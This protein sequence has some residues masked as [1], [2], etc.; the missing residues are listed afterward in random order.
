MKFRGIIAFV[1]ALACSP[2]L[3]QTNPG[4]S[5]LSIAKGG[6]NCSTPS[7]VCLGNIIGPAVGGIDQNLLSSHTANYTLSTTDCGSTVT[8]GGNAFFTL[9]VPAVAG[10]PASCS[11]AVVNI[12]T[13]GSGRAKLISGVTLPGGTGSGIQN[14]LWPTQNFSIKIENGSWTV[15]YAPLRIK[16]QGAA[17]FNTDFVNGNDANDGLATGAGN[18]FKTVSQCMQNIY[19]IFDDDA[20][21][22]GVTCL[23]AAGTTDSTTIHVASHGGFPGSFGTSGVT[24]DGNGTAT[25]SGGIQIYYG[26]VIAVQAVTLTN[27]GGDCVQVQFGGHIS[28]NAGVTFGACSGTAIDIL[29]GGYG[30]FN[31]N[32]TWSGNTP[33]F[34][35]L[36]NG[37]IFNGNGVTVTLGAN[38]TVTETVAANW[39]SLANLNAMTWTLGA[40]TVTG[41]KFLCAGNS[42]IVGATGI[43]GTVAGSVSGG[44]NLDGNPT[45]V[46][47]GGTGLAAGT[48]G[49]I[50][51]FQ[52]STQMATSAL[53]A[54]NQLM[55]GG[56]TGAPPSTLGSLGTTTQVLHGNAG[57]LPTWAQVGLTADVTG[58]LPGGNGGTNNAFMQFSGPATSTKTYTLP[59]ASA[60][61]LTTNGAVFSSTVTNPTGTTSV[62]TQKM[63]GMGATCTITPTTSTRVHFQ[64]VGQVLNN[65]VND[66][67][68]GQLAYGTGTAPVNGAAAT[69]TNIGNG[70]VLS[71][72]TAGTGYPFNMSGVAT[73]LTPGTAVWFDLSLSALVGGTASVSNV[74]CVAFEM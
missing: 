24:I 57:G 62:G 63:M 69:G 38:A 43:P 61:I 46:S 65:T 60:S 58:T 35:L 47:A 33:I 32:V 55:A 27:A 1:F 28:F 5:P 2:A 10:F 70:P 45:Q 53:L 13:F 42:T 71:T 68:F 50:P 16:H 56:G 29:N 8:L 4:T 25:L 34:L 20:G 12:D 41:K 6:T 59:N 40:F 21:L 9:T 72:A 44:C 30:A 14:F 74:T 73:S 3:A 51:W 39:N 19:T 15:F 37:A 26:T 11:V 52:F 31:N 64:F 7:I 49:G 54:Q 18:A 67:A 66:G 23:M 36:Q 17:V 48:Q 22:N